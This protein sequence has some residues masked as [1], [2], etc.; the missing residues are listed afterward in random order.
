MI[1]QGIANYFKNLKYFFT[2]LGTLALG[3]IF[4]LS[5]FIPGVVSSLSA[6]AENVK[7]VLSD[8]AV[9]FTALK[10]SIVSAVQSLNW[11]APIDAI[12]T[13]VDSDW[14]MKTLNDCVGAFVESTDVYI[15]G[16]K[17]AVD[18]FTADLALYFSAVVVFVFLGIIGGF[19]LTKWLIRRNMAKRSLWKYLLNSFIDSLISSTLVALCVWLISVWQPSIFISSVI[20][21]SLFGFISLFEAYIVH[22]WKKVDL[23]EIVNGKNI[24]KLFATNMIILLISGIMLLIAIAITNVIAG[25]FIGIVL[26]EIAL[27]VIG[28]N[29]EAYVKSAAEKGSLDG[30]IE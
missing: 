23:K 18:A 10:N 30:K 21:V 5:V 17:V 26:M 29:A 12:R 20:T 22:A 9:D 28:L 2:P 19:F 8:T 11:D 15:A 3:F 7:T 1:K 6:L 24:L 25:I 4:G 14:L 16:L 27:I 13:M